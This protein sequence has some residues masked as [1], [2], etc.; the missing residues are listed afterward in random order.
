ML[1]TG[2][3]MSDYMESLMPPALGFFC[4]TKEDDQ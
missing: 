3:W 4:F 1:D 2:R